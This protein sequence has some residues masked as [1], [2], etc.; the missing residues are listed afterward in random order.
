MA[1][2]RDTGDLIV[3]YIQDLT[4][5]LEVMKA[6]DFVDADKHIERVSRVANTN[7][8]LT[9]RVILEVH[10]EIKKYK[11][12]LVKNN[13]NCFSGKKLDLLDKDI[14]DFISARWKTFKDED[15]KLIFKMLK[16]MFN[17]GTQI[18]KNDRKR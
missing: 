6:Y 17:L 2:T 18:I 16:S 8:V 7:A 4:K 3:E 5:I 15:K 11:S 1:T 14:S 13:F 9:K 10:E 12:D